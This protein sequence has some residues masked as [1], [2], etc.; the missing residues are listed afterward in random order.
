MVVEEQGGL[1]QDL[2]GRCVVVLQVNCR[3]EPM[4]GPAQALAVKYPEWFKSYRDF[5][6]LFRDGYVKDT[7]GDVHAFKASDGL[8][9]CGVLAQVGTGKNS[10]ATSWGAWEKGLKWLK[11]R[12]P[13]LGGPGEGWK[14]RIQ[15]FQDEGHEQEL[16][17]LVKDAFEASGVDVSVRRG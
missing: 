11:A 15:G 16:L 4:P 6:S 13:R 3:G 8:I 9:V 2:P 1:L 17:R 12:V 7:L 10:R 5:C 14:V